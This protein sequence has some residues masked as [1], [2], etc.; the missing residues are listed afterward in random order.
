[1]SGEVTYI[2]LAYLEMTEA[3]QP[4]ESID[5]AVVADYIEVL[6]SAESNSFPPVIVFSDGEGYWLADGFHRALAAEGAGLPDIAAHV[7]PGN[8]RDAILYACGA[9]AD[10]GLRRTN[11][12][13]RKAVLTLLEDDAWSQW[14]DREIARRCK[15]SDRLVNN[16]RAELTANIRSE[17]DTPDQPRTYTDRHGNT[18]TMRTGNIGRR[19]EVEEEEGPEMAELPGLDG[20]PVE[21]EEAEEPTEAERLADQAAAMLP[22]HMRDAERGKLEAEAERL[23]A[24]RERRNRLNPPTKG[25][26]A[27]A[28]FIKDCEALVDPD[29]DPEQERREC[30]ICYGVYGAIQTILETPSP[31]EVLAM[32]KPHQEYRLERIWDAVNWLIEFADGLQKMQHERYEKSLFEK[33]AS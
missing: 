16:L 11:A 3:C 25:D 30:H 10:H 20:A 28:K 14:S 21:A 4:R 27:W 5:L 26:P 15:V 7:L 17:T 24:Q 13:K 12:D 1:M 18:T 2:E 9:N 23:I 29:V 33:D 32:V 19:S 22:E 31:E 8:E 6:E